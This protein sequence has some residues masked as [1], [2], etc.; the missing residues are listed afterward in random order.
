[1][2]TFVPKLKKSSSIEKSMRLV[3]RLVQK[4]PEGPIRTNA[5][6][7]FAKLAPAFPKNQAVEVSTT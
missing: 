7:C 2:V 3:T 1:M 4:D 6:I 5:V